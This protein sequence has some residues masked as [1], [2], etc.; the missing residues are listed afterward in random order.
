MSYNRIHPLDLLRQNTTELCFVDVRTAAEV[1]AECLPHCL[2]IPLHELTAERLNTEISR[3]GKP[4]ERVYLVCQTGRRAEL[5]IDQLAGQASAELVILEGG[6]EACKQ[7]HIPLQTVGR[8]VLPLERQVRIAAG[9]LALGGALLGF[10][11]HPGFHGVSAF[12]G[13]GLIFAGITDICPMAMLI[14][15]MPWNR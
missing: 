1:N 4:F 8:K 6:I 7:H 13:C 9:V 11:V 3:R 5:A 15:K 14:A 10:W 12:V 2:N